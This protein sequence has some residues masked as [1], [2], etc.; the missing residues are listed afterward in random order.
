MAYEVVDSETPYEGDLVTVRLDTVRMPDG[1]LADREVVEHV[2]SVAVVAFR[3]TGEILLIRQYRHPAGKHLWELPAGLCDREGEPP[4][5][6]ARRELAE[7]TGWHAAQW[8]TLID[9]RPSPGMSNE[10]VRVYVARHL[11]QRHRDGDN[12]GEEQDLQSRWVN[13]PEAVREVLDGAISNGP[14]VAGILA[15]AVGAG[16]RDVGTRAADAAWPASVGSV[17][18]A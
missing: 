12:S 9:V 5:D 18:H 14:A 7:E 3:K 13:L 16:I 4:L 17:Q 15:A 1:S 11:S 6:T 2:G 10:V 8:C